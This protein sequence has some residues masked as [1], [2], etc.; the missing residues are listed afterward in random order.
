MR[1]KFFNWDAVP[2]GTAQDRTIARRY[3][4]SPSSVQRERAKR[5]IPAFAPPPPAV[6]W[7]G[8]GLGERPDAVIARELGV[9]DRAVSYQRE[10]RGIGPYGTSRFNHRPR[11]R[12]LYC[13]CGK[14]AV[15]WFRGAPICRA[16]LC[17]DF[18]LSTAAEDVC[19]NARALVSLLTG[20]TG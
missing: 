20:A 8:V 11:L 7:D 14:K 6:D 4:C 16:C 13:P 12:G 17:P 3:G 1:K 9:T 2:L 10:K 5:G 15:E 18:D 19:A